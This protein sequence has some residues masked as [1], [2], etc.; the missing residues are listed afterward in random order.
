MHLY[1]TFL[2]KLLKQFQFHNTCVDWIRRNILHLAVEIKGGNCQWLSSA[3]QN[4]AQL[5][6]SFLHTDFP[7]VKEKVIKEGVQTHGGTGPLIGFRASVNS[8]IKC[9]NCSLPVYFPD[10]RVCRTYQILTG[11]E[12]HGLVQCSSKL[13]VNLNQ[14]ECLPKIPVHASRGSKL[15]SLSGAWGSEFSHHVI[16]ILVNQEIHFSN[17]G[18]PYPWRRDKA[19]KD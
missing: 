8:L 18:L 17:I 6:L 5:V 13:P 2:L 4:R 14:S 3:E 7:G 9:I 15:V 16:L 1:G 19:I 11:L 10:L 12:D